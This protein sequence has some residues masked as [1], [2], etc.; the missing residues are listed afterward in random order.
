MEGEDFFKDGFLRGAHSAG[1]GGRGVVVARE[2]E[3]AVD[4]VEGE[5]GG[6]VVTEFL[7]AL[8]GNGG[9]DENFAVGKRDHI[10]GAGDAE[11]V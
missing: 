10:G 9:A 3:E 8:L 11:K 2:M 7:R 1:L 4:E 6:G 5:F